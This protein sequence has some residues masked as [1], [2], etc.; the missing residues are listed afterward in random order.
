MADLKTKDKTV[1]KATGLMGSIIGGTE[2]MVDVKDGKI[3]RVRP[4][5][6]DTSNK[7]QLRGWKIVRNGRTLEPSTKSLPTPWNLGYKKRTYSPN[8]ILY[9]LR[10]VDWDPNGERN[11]QNRGK[12]KY[13]RISWDEATEIVAGEIRRIHE[14]YGVYGIL[15]M[16]D[17]HGES[18]T[19]HP[20]HGQPGALLE[21]MGGFTISVRNPDSWEGWY[22]GTKHVWGQGAQGQ[23]QGFNVLKDVTEHADMVLCWGCDPETT[24]WGFSG[25]SGSRILYFW[26]EAGIKLVFIC[27]DLNY[28]AALHADKWIPVYP[29]TDAALQ[30]AIAYVWIAEGTY[31]KEYVDTHVAGF[32][33]FR[34]Y[35]MGEED[36]VAKTPK[37]ASEKCGVP[38]WTIKALAREF[39]RQTTSI[40]HTHGGGYIR[41][42]YSHEPAR[43]EA[44]L[45]AMQGLGGPG[46]HPIHMTWIGNPRAQVPKSLSGNPDLPERLI[47]PGLSGLA[48][49]Q[50]QIVPKTLINKAIQSDE[51]I[52]F[53]GTAAIEALVKDQFKKYTYP[54]PKEKGGT[55]F[56]MIWSDAPCRPTCWNAGMKTQMAL[57][58]PKI[59]T[60]VVQ[61]PWMENDCC[62]ADIVLPTNTFMEIDDLI[63][64][65]VP[66]LQRSGL[67]YSERAVTP[68]GESKT[69]YEAMVEVAKKLDMEEQVTE[70][71]DTNEIYMQVI[72]GHVGADLPITLEELK[73]RKYFP[74]GF[75]PDWENDP[76]G[77]RLFYEDPEKH[78][79]PTPTG[80]LEFY[81]ARLAEH[82][83]DDDERA[84]I[85]KW[86]EKGPTHDERRTSDRAKIFPLILMSNHGRWRMHAQCDDISWSRE[87]PTCKV[88]GPD[89]Y[90]YEPVWLNPE[91]ARKR[92]IKNGD[93][94]KI[95]N[96]LGIVLA[97]AYVTERIRPGVAYIDHGARVDAI[98][99]GAIDRGGAINLISPD[100]TISRNCPGMATSGYLVQVE[101]LSAREYEQWRAEYPEAFEREYEPNSGLQFSAWIE[102]GKE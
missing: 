39:A 100:K 66:G 38:S 51:P 94:V 82:F 1:L 86:V 23:Y 89:G 5:H 29:N 27:P 99:P 68:V 14:K 13:V 59:E 43:L 96:E 72:W 22:Y 56:H 41:S 44:C 11:P 53:T 79:L 98:E 67:I 62:F 74:Y 84:P 102:R 21:Q 30:L 49:W 37:W 17:G 101:R 85:P 57:R 77:F 90:K 60:V 31:N 58:S 64:N 95:S 18:K 54:L 25:Q 2:A 36:G 88:T 24:S 26:K 3:V 76:P 4:F 33:K 19:L 15:H 6:Y 73:E 45:L 10:R 28:S 65:T 46:V 91:E 78:P 97:G 32:D 93:I 9:P 35:V 40:G 92:G 50:E 42:A 69:D 20:A 87:A 70:G 83:P 71:Y 55:E 47:N 81:S 34:A 52:S 8:R 7:E 16:G 75:A 48:A 12:S 63:N 80:R 61:H